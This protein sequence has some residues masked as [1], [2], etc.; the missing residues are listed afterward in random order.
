MTPA[1]REAAAV[2]CP[3]AAG[4]EAVADAALLLVALSEGFDV[5]DDFAVA[6]GCAVVVG[7]GVTSTR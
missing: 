4:A 1:G 5:A 6:E 3:E 2:G 7:A